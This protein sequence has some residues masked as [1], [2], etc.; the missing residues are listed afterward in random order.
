MGRLENVQQLLALGHHPSARGRMADSKTPAHVASQYG[1]AAVVRALLAGGA[2]ANAPARH[3]SSGAGWTPLHV[4]AAAGKGEVVQALLA[5]GAD[6]CRVNSDGATPL[7]LA[8]EQV[9]PGA[10]WP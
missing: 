9:K 6:P 2:D 8:A 7:H 5:A 1:H 3:G 10:G 4:A